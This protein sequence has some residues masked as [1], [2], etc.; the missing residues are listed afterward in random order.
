MKVISTTYS[1]CLN[2][3]ALRAVLSYLHSA[4]TA[5]SAEIR[6]VYTGI[7]LDMRSYFTAVIHKQSSK[8]IEQSRGWN[9][10]M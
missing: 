10:K 8:N 9:V 5:L 3:V 7:E 1:L 6:L 4:R 2:F